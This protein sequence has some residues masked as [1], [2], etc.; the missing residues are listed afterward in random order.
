M[1]QEPEIILRDD[2]FYEIKFLYPKDRVNDLVNDSWGK[3]NS[4]L[5][6]II[7]H[8]FAAQ[9]VKD[10]YDKLSALIDLDLVKLLATRKL[11]GVVAGNGEK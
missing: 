7:T 9:Y 4:H 3:N 11:A 1:R 8:I 6:D 2:G 5:A 10:N